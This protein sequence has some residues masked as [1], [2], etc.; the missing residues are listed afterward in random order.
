[1]NDYIF[2]QEYINN[3]KKNI[4][5]FISRAKININKITFNLSLYTDFVI[6]NE[7]TKDITVVLPKII[8]NKII[9]AKIIINKK[10]FN[11]IKG[12]SYIKPEYED[13]LLNKLTRILVEA[14]A[15]KFKYENMVPVSIEYIGLIHDNMD[16]FD[17][18]LSTIIAEDINDYIP[19]TDK[20][21]YLKGITRM[22]LALTG[23]KYAIS[24]YF[25]HDKSLFI[26]LYSLSVDTNLFNKINSEMTLIKD[27]INLSDMDIDTTV[28]NKYIRAKEIELINMIINKLYIPLI[29]S[30]PFDKRRSVRDEILKGFLGSNYT[31]L[32]LTNDN[33]EAYFFASL[34]NNS[35]PIN[36]KITDQSWAYYREQVN[37]E[38]YENMQD[39]YATYVKN[40]AK[41]NIK[42]FW[43]FE[44]NNR[45]Y[46]HTAKKDITEEKLVLEMLSYAYI[47][48]V[49]DDF[50]A[51]IEEGIN[52][53]CS[54]NKT[55]T[56]S[57]NGNPLSNRMLVA[58]IIQLANKNNY[59]IKL[60]SMTETS[61]KF[62]VN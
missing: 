59:K 47:S 36:N 4:V 15:I 20:Y 27:L 49:D 51:K 16:G 10:Y 45:M 61:A 58:A 60:E 7:S 13:I 62:V 50:K 29:N 48:S 54:T 6:D 8:N 9:G 21:M 11:I 14:A 37:K 30:T 24:T 18:G 52:R 42:E 19:P 26:A 53:L 38:N 25:N 32:K 57:L 12:A 34:V 5:N 31:N 28:C 23:Y 56:S 3:I 46:I 40:N 39:I 35:V 1:M 22:V 41:N 43:L 2:N 55:F 17:F 44:K 33:K